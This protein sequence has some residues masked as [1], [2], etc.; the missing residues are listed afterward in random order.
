MLTKHVDKGFLIRIYGSC[1]YTAI[2]YINYN[3]NNKQYGYNLLINVGIQY[4]CFF[5][6]VYQYMQ[7][8]L[9]AHQPIVPVL[10]YLSISLMS[11]ILSIPLA[12][13]N[14]QIN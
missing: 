1:L 9:E 10:A 14:L 4:A 5:Q 2:R 8:I 3:N 13:R 7:R 6:I 11:R 12:F